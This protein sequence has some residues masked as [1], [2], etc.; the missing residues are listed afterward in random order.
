MKEYSVVC[1][2]EAEGGVSFN[3]GEFAGPQPSGG[4]GE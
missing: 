1:L 4:R 2:A 3:L